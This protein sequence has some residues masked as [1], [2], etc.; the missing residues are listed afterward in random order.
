MTAPPAGIALKVTYN[1]N[2]G[3]EARQGIVGFRGVCSD[4]TIL[5]NVRERKATNCA[6][7]TPCARY[8]RGGMKPGKRPVLPR[9]LD[10]TWCYE[11]S[12]LARR[13]WGFGAGAY[14]RGEKRGEPIPMRRGERGDIA[15]LTTRFPGQSEAERSVF[16]L[17]RIGKRIVSPESGTWL[18]SDGSMQVMLPSA[19][20]RDVRYWDYAGGDPDWRMGLFRYVTPEATA[21]LLAEVTYLLGDH[22]DRDR[23]LKAVGPGIRPTPPPRREWTPCGEGEAHRKLKKRVAQNPALI[24]LSVD[25]RPTIE[26]TFISGDR[27]DIAFDVA[28]KPKAVVE[29]ETYFTEPGAYQAI[30]YRALMEAECGVPLGSGK[31]EAILVAHTCD[32][33]THSIA[34]RYGVRVVVID[35]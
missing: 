13:R 20:A 24:G 31:V 4:A 7:G 14:H 29:I 3:D 25:A 27:V 33:R 6:D 22:D 32:E 8:V 12:V 11:S 26:R 1:D 5:M 35:P 9:S 19:L 34:K 18:E 10:D 21:R 16:A 30:K 2:D 15:I 28:G 17:Y 23:I